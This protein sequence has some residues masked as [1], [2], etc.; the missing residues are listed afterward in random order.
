M[1]GKRPQIEAYVAQRY[2]TVTGNKLPEAPDNIRAAPDAWKELAQLKS[3]KRKRSDKAEEGRNGALYALGCRLQAQGKSD[4][5]IIEA[6]ASANTAAN[7]GLHPNFA[8]GALSKDEVELIAKSVLKRPKGESDGDKLER[9]NREYCVVQDGGR[10]RA[11]YFDRQVQLKGGMVVHERL[12]PT[13]LSFGDFH[14]YFRNE[15]VKGADGKWVPLGSWW[16]SHPQ[17]RT[18]LGL[19]FRPDVAHDVIDGRLNLWRGWGI[20]VKVGDWS[21]LRQHISEVIAGGDPEAEKY[22]MNWLA[23]TVQNPADRAE[24]ALVLKGGRGVGKGTLGNA[25]VRMFGQ[26]A[27]H[28]SSADHL[29]GRFNAHLRD[30]CFLFA[31]EAYWPGDK[32]AEGMLKRLITEPTLFIEAKG[33]D[34]ITV[35]NMLHVLMASNEEWVVPAGEHER[36]YAIFQVSESKRQDPS[37]FKPLYEQMENGGYGAMLHDLLQLDLG[38]WHPRNIPATEALRQQQE[39]SIKPLDAWILKFF[40]DGLLPESV[41]V[42]APNRALSRS[43]PDVD[44][45]NPRNG[46]YDLAREQPNLRHVDEQVLA[47]HLKQWGLTSW[48]NSRSRGW[49]FPPLWQCRARWEEKYPG[50]KWQYPDLTDWQGD[51]KTNPFTHPKPTY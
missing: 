26:H 2:F 37:W 11:L 49:E 25:L 9:M 33:R 7:V 17:R 21:L 20:Q 28:I 14:N 18:Y 45:R 36:R 50:W 16:T 6:L 19:T 4:D 31:D 51:D 27:T 38:D 41:D 3:S 29:A 40:E 13:F 39:R 12:V 8:E 47:S 5:E 22:I 24:V 42:D 1:N 34:G 35:P 46:L 23:W 32:S 15:R 30:V 44:G 48:R 43:K 10:T